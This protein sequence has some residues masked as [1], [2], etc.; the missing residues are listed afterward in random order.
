MKSDVLSDLRAYLGAA[1]LLCFIKEIGF[2]GSKICCHIDLPVCHSYDPSS[3]L[4]YALHS[5]TQAVQLV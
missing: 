4:H 2:F 3:G 5:F 1:L